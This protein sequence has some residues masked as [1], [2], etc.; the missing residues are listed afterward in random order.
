MSLVRFCNLWII[1]SKNQN[2]NF[3]N[4]ILHKNVKFISYNNHFLSDIILKVLYKK[5][6]KK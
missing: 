3:A 6:D 4:I 1:F 2:Y 5:T